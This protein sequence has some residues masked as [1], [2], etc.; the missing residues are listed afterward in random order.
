VQSYFEKYPDEL[1]TWEAFM[2][3]AQDHNTLERLG[4]S[5][6]AGVPE[7]DKPREL[8]HATTASARMGGVAQHEG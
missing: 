5:G 7:P 6:A 4:V 2:D 3:A 1:P 8:G